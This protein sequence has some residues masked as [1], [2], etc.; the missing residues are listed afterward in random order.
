MKKHI[1]Q[2]LWVNY[3]DGTEEFGIVAFDVS[4]GGWL[5]LQLRLDNFPIID[6]LVLKPSHIKSITLANGLTISKDF[7]GKIK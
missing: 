1:H 3:V 7:E 5:L 2:Y 4:N 6:T